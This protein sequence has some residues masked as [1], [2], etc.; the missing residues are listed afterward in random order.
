[1]LSLSQIY[2]NEYG[3]DI[4]DYA[5]STQNLSLISTCHI[6]LGSFLALSASRG[7]LNRMDRR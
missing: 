6:I 3:Y 7:I 2:S 5:F 1:M 4:I